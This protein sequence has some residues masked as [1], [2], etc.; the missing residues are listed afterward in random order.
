MKTPS[1]RQNTFST[2][3]VQGPLD[4]KPSPHSM[5]HIVERPEQDCIKD[6]L[7]VIPEEDEGDKGQGVGDEPVDSDEPQSLRYYNH[8][9]DERPIRPRFPDSSISSASSMD[10]AS[11][12]V[13]YTGIQT[14][15]SSL[16]FQP[17]PQT[18]P[19]SHQPNTDHS[20][21][22]GSGGGSYRPQMHPITLSENIGL[23]SPEPLLEPQAVSSGG[24]KPQNSWHFDSP[25]EEERS[26]LAPSLGSPVSVASTQFLLPDEEDHD[27]EK[28]QTSAATWFSNLLSSS[29]P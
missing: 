27:E 23:A 11:T 3:L 18:T 17:D 2:S 29:K 20:V 15:C 26:G 24:Y 21:S 13:T 14:S 25:T 7:L 6:A 5:V 22:C 28:L 4:V 16:V 9:A 12:D 19:E 10:S 8:V 1:N